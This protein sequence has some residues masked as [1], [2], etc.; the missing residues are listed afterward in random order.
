M[1]Q[2]IVLLILGVA[3][4]YVLLGA[5]MY[6]FQRKLLYFPFK[7][8]ISPDRVGLPEAEVRKIETADGETLVSW[9]VRGPGP[10]IAIYFH[11]QGE[12]LF[13]RG[14]RIKQLS[15]LGLSVL[16]IDYRGFGGSTGTPTEAG[17]HIDADAAYDEALTLGFV[18]DHI[19]L[20]GESLGSGV[21]LE[22]AT[23]RQ[24]AGVMLDSPYSSVIDVAADRYWF[25][26]VRML[27]TDQFHSDLWIPQV[28]VPIL[29][30]HGTDDWIIPVKYGR[31]LASLGGANVTFT[32]VPNAGHVVFDK[33]DEAA[34]TWLAQFGIQGASQ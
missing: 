25:L 15:G 10:D 30:V 29:I 20:L 12:S 2:I 11:G 31:R 4:L 26:P 22:L 7:I 1:A 5:G 27:L 19:L 17:L 34:R 32:E 16:A 24:L 13:A 8:R 23:R 33:V 6:V 14:G 21:A 18:A 9:F 28:H 3:V